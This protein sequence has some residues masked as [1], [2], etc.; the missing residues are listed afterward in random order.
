MSVDSVSWRQL[1]FCCRNHA[2][3]VWRMTIDDRMKKGTNEG[4]FG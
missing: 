1:S 4:L 3:A 2:S